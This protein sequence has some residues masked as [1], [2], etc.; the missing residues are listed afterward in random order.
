M[1]PLILFKFGMREHL[2]QF[3][4]GFLYMNSQA[5]FAAQEKDPPRSD[6]LEGT[7]HMIQP[8]DIGNITIEVPKLNLKTIILPA[9]LAAATTFA[10]EKDACNIFC[11]FAVKTFRMGVF[12]PS[13]D[14]RNYQFG[15]SFVVVM[16]TSKFLNRVSAGIKA[17]GFRGKAALVEYKDPNSH[18]GPT[19]PFWKSSDFEY[20]NEF[21][22]IAQPGSAV[23]RKLPIGDLCDITSDI[24][25]MAIVN[26]CIFQM[27]P[28]AKV[29]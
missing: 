13:V 12:S 23:A 5:W 14:P 18:S 26:S 15:D 10:L 25:P 24:G 28:S 21:R 2:Q 27:A 20:Q 29:A 4:E 22:I 8:R 9:D 19:G 1:K 3:R 11:M 7:S 17:A 6:P 16:N